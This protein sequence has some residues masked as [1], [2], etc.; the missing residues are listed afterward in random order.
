MV[1]SHGSGTSGPEAPEGLQ[2]SR[3]M[4]QFGGHDASGAAPAD[5]F[6]IN[7]LLASSFQHGQ[8]QPRDQED[9]SDPDS[10]PCWGALLTGG[11]LCTPGFKIGRLHFKNKYCDNVRN[12]LLPPPT[13]LTSRRPLS[14]SST[15]RAHTPARP[16]PQ[17]PRR[18]RPNSS[19]HPLLSTPLL[20]PNC[21]HSPP[22][23]ATSAVH[24]IRRHVNHRLR[25]LLRFHRLPPPC[26]PPC[27]FSRHPAT[28]LPSPPLPTSFP[29]PLPPSPYFLL[30][31]PP[32][33]QRGAHARSAFG[34]SAGRASWYHS[35]RSAPSPPSRRSTPPTGGARGSGTSR[36]PP[37]AAASTESSTT[38]RRAPQPHP[39][40]PPLPQPHRS[41]SRI[42]YPI[43]NR[44]HAG[45]LVLGSLSSVTRRL[46]WSGP[47][48]RPTCPPP[49]AL[50]TPH[51][52]YT[53]LSPHALPLPPCS[54]SPPTLSPTP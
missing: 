53:L 18:T 16:P 36:P 19:Q 12:P 20:P 51:P 44:G 49:P 50:R 7:D 39:P 24:H 13:P 48:S 47:P 46:T 27:V 26:N 28:P 10:G 11:D 33:P 29:C 35:R 1:R 9:P 14:A 54:P 23:T 41:R 32:S 52:P 4:A 8:Q 6:D 34:R 25:R 17:S 37:W 22:L 45:A 38:L 2:S 42:T 5:F 31:P 21:S 40:T 3:T 43:P 15:A 30:M